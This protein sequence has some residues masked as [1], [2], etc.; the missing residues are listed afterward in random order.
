MLT[1]LMLRELMLK[2]PMLRE[3]IEE[4]E[5][6]EKEHAVRFKTSTHNQGVV[7]INK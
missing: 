5:G 7:G 1:G 2:E 3:L 4:E 6:G